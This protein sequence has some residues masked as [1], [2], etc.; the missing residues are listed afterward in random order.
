MFIQLI[1]IQICILFNF[2]NIINA[3]SCNISENEYNALHDLFISTN[4]SY[5]NND[6]KKWIFPS[7]LNKQ[8]D[9]SSIL[10]HGFKC[11]EISPGLCGIEQMN[12]GFNNIQGN[13]TKKIDNFHNLTKLELN[14]NKL[15]KSI[16]TELG[17]L[18]HLVDLE[19]SNN[20][21]SKSIPTEL[22]NLINLE[23]LS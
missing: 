7:D 20:Q 12:L 5:W 22:G 9:T 13:I 15:S 18:I 17:N 10:W 8:C 16:P 11:I 21:L 3:K 1:I 4:G 19:L 2:I 14:N 23:N 6:I